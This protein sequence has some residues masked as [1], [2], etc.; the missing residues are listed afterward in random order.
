MHTTNQQKLCTCARFGQFRQRI[1]YEGYQQRFSS[2]DIDYTGT[3]KRPSL[4]RQSHNCLL[5]VNPDAICCGW[6]EPLAYVHQPLR[7]PQSFRA[8]FKTY[9]H[10]YPCRWAFRNLL[11]SRPP[12]PPNPPQSMFIFIKV[13]FHN[14]FHFTWNNDNNV[15][16]V[17][18]GSG[19]CIAFWVAFTLEYCGKLSLKHFL[20]FNCHMPM[21]RKAYT[22]KH[23][24]DVWIWRDMGKRRQ[25]DQQQSHMRQICPSNNEHKTDNREI[26]Y[27]AKIW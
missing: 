22:H 3:I 23:T 10:F 19:H 17:C 12:P 2:D 1:N 21:R 15:C 26:F 13:V 4:A 25:V 9:A 20:N 16:C 5:I 24:C 6:F 27:G 7:K 14:L 8:L 11:G 18:A